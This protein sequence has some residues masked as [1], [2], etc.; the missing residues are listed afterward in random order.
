MCD[1]GLLIAPEDELSRYRRQLARASIDHRPFPPTIDNHITERGH[2]D[3][4]SRVLDLAAGP[5]SL[6]LELAMRT[7]QGEPN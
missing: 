1:A 3:T 6:A 7:P 4:N 2:I 5:G